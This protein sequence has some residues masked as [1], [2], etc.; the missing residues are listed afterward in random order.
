MRIGGIYK[1]NPLVGSFVV[2]AGFFLSH[3]NNPLPIG[4]LVSTAPGAADLEPAL[5]PRA[6]RRTRTSAIKTRAQFEQS[7]AE[8]VN[9]ELGLVYVL[10]ALAVARSR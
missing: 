4:V 2:G 8:Q 1:P 3:F 6:R 10:L 9:Q 7:A 5:E